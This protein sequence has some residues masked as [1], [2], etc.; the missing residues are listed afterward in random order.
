MS[1]TAATA[2][3]EDLVKWLRQIAQFRKET[4]MKGLAPKTPYACVEDFVLRHGRAW[5]S[6]PYNHADWAPM[7]RGQLKQCFKN[8]FLMASRF[9]DRL[10]Y[11]EGIGYHIIPMVHA[12]CVDA[13]GNVVDPTWRN[14]ET[15]LY[16]G[17][18]FRLDYVE[19]RVMQ[20]GTYCSMLDDYQGGFPLLTGKVAPESAVVAQP[21]TQ[22]PVTSVYKRRSSG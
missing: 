12:W 21:Q 1:M 22:Q 16:F 14:P 5:T 2:T 20:T 19:R 7:K 15:R 11:C 8:A 13:A 18:V 9:P 3:P 4:V 17:C 6:K 10:R